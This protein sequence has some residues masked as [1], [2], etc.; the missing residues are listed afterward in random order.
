MTYYL[1][2]QSMAELAYAHPDL[3]RVVLAAIEISKQDF[4]VHDCL[5]TIEE[6]RQMVASGASQTM[7]SL[8]L[9]QPDGYSHAVDLY[10]YLNGKLRG[11]WSLIWPVA[12]AMQNAS[13]RLGVKLR[14]GGAW[15][16]EFT[17]GTADLVRMQR[18]YIAKR[19][20]GKKK[21]FLDG[22]H[23]ELLA[24]ET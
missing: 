11:E 15:T 12:K 19:R 21:I 10:P 16:E 13:A 2:E 4:A 20:G 17:F 18:A 5:R 8:H 6:Q 22:F 9:K 7:E 1:G 23:F 3:K 14:W 24:T